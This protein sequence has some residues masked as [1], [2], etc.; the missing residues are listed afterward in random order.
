MTRAP[1]HSSYT[2]SLALIALALLLVLIGAAAD[3]V[4]APEGLS[5]GATAVADPM[6]FSMP[7]L[8]QPAESIPAMSPIAVSVSSMPTD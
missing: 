7:E 4:R 6:G 3:R 2:W 8:Q 5:P 1:D